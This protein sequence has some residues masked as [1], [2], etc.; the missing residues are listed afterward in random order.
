MP[1]RYR[2]EAAQDAWKLMMAFLKKCFTGGWAKD[3][4]SCTYESDY[5]TTYDFKK[6]VRME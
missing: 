5:S 1:G 6:N 4:I 3:R 2:K